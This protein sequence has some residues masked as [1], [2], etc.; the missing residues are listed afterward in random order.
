MIQPIETERLILRRPAPRDQDICVDFFMSERAAGVGGPFDLHAAWRHFAYE[1]GHWE[2]NNFGMWAVT[3]KGDDTIL[4]LIGPWHPADWPEREIGWM[5]FGNAEG[6]SI[7]YE[8]A[9]AAIKHARTEL[10]WTDFVSYISEGLDRSIALAERL[11]AALDKN[12]KGPEAHP[13]LVYRHPM[14]EAL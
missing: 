12:A 11:G 5:V 7:A 2:I 14:Q 3:M 4:G 1:L 8:A 6:K 13:C 9:E 10:G